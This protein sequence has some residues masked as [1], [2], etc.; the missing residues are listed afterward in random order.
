MLGN[1]R[2]RINTRKFQNDMTTFA[3]KDDVLTLLVHLGYL[4][5][6]EMTEEVYIPNQEI[7]Q[8]FLN[9]VD[10]PGWDGLIQALNH[11]EELVRST[12]EMDKK[13]VAEGLGRIHNETASILQYNNENSLTCTILIAYYSA[14]AY[15]AN[16]VM[17]MP[18][19]K[20]FADV[21][22]IPKRGIDKPALVV[23]LKWDKSAGGAIA[24]IK[25]KGYTDW[26]AGYTGE[27]LLVGVN[28]DK[29]EKV[30][31][32]VIEKYKRE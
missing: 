25:E 27:I 14:R 18:A 16:P 4:T 15:Y 29:G 13:A 5:F 2:C 19:G 20:G 10:G 11:S 1:G 30:H 7:A 3:T 23:E 21:V 9:V 26:L 12:W 28:Y 31:Q 22:Y 17:E 32:C 8:E 24:Q 6:D